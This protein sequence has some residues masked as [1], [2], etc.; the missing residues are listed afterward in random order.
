MKSIVEVKVDNGRYLVSKTG[1]RKTKRKPNKLTE[2]AMIKIAEA[3]YRVAPPI[4]AKKSWSKIR[5][6]LDDFTQDAVMDM[7]RLYEKGYFQI[8]KGH[9]DTIVYRMINGYFII[10]TLQ[11]KRKIANRMV[12]ADTPIAGSGS[13]GKTALLDIIANKPGEDPLEHEYANGV[14]QEIINKLDFTPVQGTKY[15][16]SGVWKDKKEIPLTQRHIARL[17]FAGEDIHGILKI[18]G[19]DTKNI[20]ACSQASHIRQTVMNTV[21]KIKEIVQTMNPADIAQL[22][23]VVFKQ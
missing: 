20:G 3:V 15:S 16:Y 6:D 21:K 4:Y 22:E 13:L 19:K 23:K 17:I 11:T 10:N 12:L 9:I 8:D 18:Y 14:L 7:I 5:Y 1:S 2:E